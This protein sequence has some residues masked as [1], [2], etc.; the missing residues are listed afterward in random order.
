MTLKEIKLLAAPTARGDANFSMSE[1][2]IR[3]C[4]AAEVSRHGDFPPEFEYSAARAGLLLKHGIYS[5]RGL[6]PSRRGGW[7]RAIKQCYR[8]AHESVATDPGRY[9]LVEGYVWSYSLG[10]IPHAWFIDRLDPGLALDPTLGPSRKCFYF[11][12]PIR[13]RHAVERILN[14]RYYGPVLADASIYDGTT[15]LENVIEKL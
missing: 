9:V 6:L 2:D 11:G 1:A 10:H 5:K 15:P 4:L 8:N 7:F 12:L 14:S 13:F 3:E